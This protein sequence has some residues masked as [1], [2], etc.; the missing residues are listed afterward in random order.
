MKIGLNLEMP[1]NNIKNIQDIE[2]GLKDL[3]KNPYKNTKGW[4][5]MFIPSPLRNTSD[6]TKKELK[7]ELK[8]APNFTFSEAYEFLY[9]HPCVADEYGFSMFETTFWFTVALVNPKTGSV[10]DIQ[11]E[12]TRTEVWVEFGEWVEYSEYFEGMDLDTVPK[13]GPSHDWRCDCGGRTFEKAIINLA[14]RV[15]ALIGNHRPRT[16]QEIEDRVF[17]SD[18]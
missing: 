12:N 11:S 16:E 17:T 8:K 4:L 7:A 18:H 9:H 3:E 1:L 13:F 15:F 6:Y 14:K 10:S 2:Y 5:P